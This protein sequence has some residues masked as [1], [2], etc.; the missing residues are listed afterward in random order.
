MLLLASISTF[1]LNLNLLSTNLKSTKLFSSEFVSPIPELIKLDFSTKTFFVP[2]LIVSKFDICILSKILKDDVCFVTIRNSLNISFE[3]KVEKSIISIKLSNSASVFENC[4]SI[5]STIKT[6]FVLQLIKSVNLIFLNNTNLELSPTTSTS[7]TK[8]ISFIS[9]TLFSLMR[10]TI[11]LTLDVDPTPT[12]ADDN[13][14]V[15]A[16]FFIP[17]V[18][19]KL[20]TCVLNVCHSIGLW[21]EYDIFW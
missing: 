15:S 10:S 1:G 14:S 9:S 19:S 3:V 2:L 17:L 7:L 20:L 11:R 6:S 8:S 16:K 21:M 12:G 5:S 4:F 18:W 13:T